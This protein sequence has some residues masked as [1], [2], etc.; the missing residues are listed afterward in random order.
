MG[1]RQL[2]LREL[3]ELT[4]RVKHAIADHAGRH[5]RVDSKDRW[6]N[7]RDR[8]EQ[9]HV[10]PF[11]DHDMGCTGAERPRGTASGIAVA[12]AVGIPIG[13]LFIVLVHRHVD[14]R[15]SAAEHQR[16]PRDREDAQKGCELATVAHADES[17]RNT[18]PAGIPARVHGNARGRFPWRAS[19]IASSE[20][21]AMSVDPVEVRARA[22]DQG[23]SCA[24]RPPAPPSR[25]LGDQLVAELLALVGARARR[26]RSVRHTRLTTGA[27]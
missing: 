22:I 14:Q 15:W 21:A 3:P 24:P 19:A 25:R 27:S 8:G 2:V 9:Q 5:A 10:R 13:A 7:P 16:H 6:L 11:G 4:R 12:G 18:A 17:Q 20:N 26:S 1:A 23:L